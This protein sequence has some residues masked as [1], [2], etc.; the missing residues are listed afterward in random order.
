MDA[1]VERFDQI[2]AWL[3][4]ILIAGILVLVYLS[5]TLFQALHYWKSAWGFLALGFLGMFESRV[6]VT[7]FAYNIETPWMRWTGRY[8]TPLQAVFGLFVGFLL[9]TRIFWRL[10]HIRALVTMPFLAKFTLDEQS[11]ILAW[12]VGAEMLFG[13]TAD[14][15]IQQDFHERLS[16]PRLR[17]NQIPIVLRQVETCG[18]E[19][20]TTHYTMTVRRRHSEPEFSV[21][22]QLTTEPNPDGTLQFCGVAFRMVPEITE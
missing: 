11:R 10:R 6:L 3:Q 1:F 20:C 21:L 15:A 14:E 4:I 13:W 18:R 9:V 17:W 5:G 2:S 12:D 8:I 16:P 7:L 22:I 19:V